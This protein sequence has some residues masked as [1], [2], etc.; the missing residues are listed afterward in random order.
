MDPFEVFAYWDSI[1]NQP[2]LTLTL[3]CTQHKCGTHSLAANSNANVLLQTT[4]YVIV[5]VQ[6]QGYNHYPSLIA[7]KHY[8]CGSE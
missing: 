2:Q 8:R 7:E 5:L 1:E 4:G 3:T 6:A